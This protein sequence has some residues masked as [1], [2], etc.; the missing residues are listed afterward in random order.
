MSTF[1]SRCGNPAAEIWFPVPLSAVDP[2]CHQACCCFSQAGTAAEKYAASS[3]VS[4]STS[5][6]LCI[7]LPAWRRSTKWNTRGGKCYLKLDL[8]ESNDT[9]TWLKV[10]Y[11]L[12]GQRNNWSE[13]KRRWK[14]QSTVR[15]KRKEN[16][17]R[18]AVLVYF[19][20]YGVLRRSACLPAACRKW[21]IA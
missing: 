4:L 20:P 9:Q 3:W 8:T 19:K 18:E 15:G 16:G 2:L 12:M 11:W 13:P 5:I 21:G 17:D 7:A 10:F 1:N 14:A 6:P